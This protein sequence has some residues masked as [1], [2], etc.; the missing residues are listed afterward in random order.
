[1]APYLISVH[2]WSAAYVPV[3]TSQVTKMP[4]SVTVRSMILPMGLS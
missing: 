4:S 2:V 1:M 3:A